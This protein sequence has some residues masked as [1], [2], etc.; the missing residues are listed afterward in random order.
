MRLVPALTALLVTVFIYAAVF[1][2]D[3]LLAFARGDQAGAEVT[4]AA[5]RPEDA[6]GAAAA[7]QD[8]RRVKVVAMRSG[9]QTIDSAVVL[10]GQTEA[11]R[12]VDVRAETTATVISEPLRRGAY[13]E[14]GDVLCQLEPG[15]RESAL[16]ETL[17]RLDEARS[18]VPEAQ[19]RLTEA[20][21][22]LE[23]ARINDNAAEKL[24]EGGFASDTRVASTRASVRAAEAG[25]TSAESGLETAQSGIRSAEAAVDAARREIE[26]LTITAPFSGILETDSAEL[27]SLMQPGSLC[28]TILQLEPIKLVGFVPETDVDRVEL[29]ARAG[30][31]LATGQQVT[32]EVTFLSRS[33]DPTTRTFR[34]DIDVPNPEGRIRDG[35]TAEIL[36][37][38][39]GVAAHKLPQSALTLDDA[40]RLGVRVVGPGDVAG[41]VPVRMVR[42]TTQGVWVTGL[43]ERADVIVVG[44][45]FVTEGV[46]VEPTFREV[47][48]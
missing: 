24:S 5:A 46:P 28:A 3:A 33:A 29:G 42:D 1:E 37:A 44:Q 2:R 19:A 17:A 32:G 16:E 41:F 6:A 15:T 43:G 45:D 13:V 40:G 39:D 10:R 38:A 12:Q 4:Q 23:E 14:T 27:G 8:A 25:V 21:A 35:Q 7:A 9:A 20:Q 18:R 30:A 47:S 36:I 34:V 26:R 31:R 11:S 22:R 48:Q